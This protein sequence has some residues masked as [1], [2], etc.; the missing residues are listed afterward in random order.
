MRKKTIYIL[1]AFVFLLFG[2]AV[3]AIE[4]IIPER[5][6]LIAGYEQSIC[7]NVPLRASL[8][9]EENIIVSGMETKPVKENIVIDL[10]KTT[11]VTPTREGTAKAEISAFGIP[12]K[13]VSVNI[14][15]QTKVITCGKVVGVVM[16]TEGVMVLGT[17]SVKKEDGKVAKPS[18]GIIKTGDII[19][20][21]NGATVTEKEEL[22]DAVSSTDGNALNLEVKRNDNLMDLE[23]IPVQNEFGEYK[24]GAWVRD[25]TQGLGTVTFI[26]PQSGKFAALGHGVYDVDTKEL[27]PVAEGV[28]TL[29][30]LSGVNKGESG[31]PG[32]IIG[33]LDKENIVGDVLTNTSSGIFGTMNAD[34]IKSLDGEELEI[35]LMQ[36]VTEGNA[37]IRSDVIDGEVK[38]Y[39]I[40][41][42]SISRF[43]TSADKGMVIRVTDDRLIDKTGG[44]IQGMSGSPII[45]NGKLVGAV[46]HVFVND[47]K[48]GYGIFIENMIK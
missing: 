38:D 24:I 40:N 18:E 31:E 42:E 41:I 8:Y 16:K 36:D 30:E 39:T 5:I 7:Y 35:G 21:C 26:E 25:S 32:E 10:N 23:V 47:A 12:L 22:K 17:G 2:T 33:M 4:F 20:S 44:I 6:N 43:G 34:G 19:I 45:Q 28:V 48:K 37:T 13:T 9:N 14:I 3:F 29:S 46:T 11:I 1:L 15:P 27:I